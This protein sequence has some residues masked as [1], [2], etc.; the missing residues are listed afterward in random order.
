M[1]NKPENTGYINKFFKFIG[2][3]DD[4]ESFGGYE[5]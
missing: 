5:L 4:E 3:T 2:N 1:D